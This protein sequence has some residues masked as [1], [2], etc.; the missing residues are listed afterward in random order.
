M[1]DSQQQF[2]LACHQLEA[3]SSAH[4]MLMLAAGSYAGINL[5]CCPQTGGQK[6]GQAFLLSIR[7]HPKCIELCW[8]LLQ[9][10]Q[11]PSAQ[12]QASISLDRLPH[13]CI[14]DQALTIRGNSFVMHTVECNFVRRLPCSC[15]MPFCRIG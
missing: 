2:E 5:V 4:A 14:A 9:H 3:S 8:G 12:F 6:E 7:N 10:S 1:A 13:S 11:G 15:A